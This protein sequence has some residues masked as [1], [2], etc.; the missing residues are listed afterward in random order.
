MAAWIW[1]ASDG[2]SCMGAV[3]RVA[4]ARHVPFEMDAVKRHCPVLPTQN[5]SEVFCQLVTCPMAVAASAR[6]S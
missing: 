1:F 4:F 3:P 5:E 2:G 6:V